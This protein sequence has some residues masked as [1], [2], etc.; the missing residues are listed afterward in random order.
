MKTFQT[1]SVT[2]W[3]ALLVVT[4]SSARLY[5][6]TPVETVSDEVLIRGF[7]QYLPELISQQ[8]HEPLLATLFSINRTPPDVQR[9]ILE[10]IYNSVIST[11]P[12]KDRIATVR[13]FDRFTLCQ[14]ENSTISKRATF[15]KNAV[16]KLLNRKIAENQLPRIGFCFSGGGIRAAVSADGF[17]KGLSKTGILDTGLYAAALS[18]STWLLA[19]WITSGKRY[20]DFAD[21]LLV[22]I[23]NGIIGKKL[24]EQIYDL[25]SFSSVIISTFLRRIA[26]EELPTVIDIYGLMLGLTLLGPNE[27]KQLLHLDLTSQAPHINQGQAPFP[28]YSAVYVKNGDNAPSYEW[29][30]FSPFEVTC[31][32]QNA[33]APAWAFGRKFEKGASKNAAP[34]LPL[35]Y[36]MGIWGS[37]ISISCGE[38]FGMI[39]NKLE[40][41]A[42]FDP[43]K[44]LLNATTVGDI[45]IFP[46]IVRNPTYHLEQSH[47]QLVKAHTIIDAGIPCNIPLPP[48]LHRNLDI[49][50]IGDFSSDLEDANELRRAEKYAR[51]HNLPFPKI[52]Y[53][54]ISTRTY[55]IFGNANG[56]APIVV[57]IPLVKNTRYLADFDPIKLMG[58]GHFMN[59]LNLNY[60]I[61]QAKTLAGLTEFTVTEM[62]QLLTKLIAHVV[63]KKTLSVPA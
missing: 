52:N 31:Y 47:D 15:C 5:A 30:E 61:D 38:L 14:D 19:P 44:Q 63:D 37:A 12:Y 7:E 11:N 27:K 1:R 53:E 41:Q 13:T 29:V 48:L 62:K 60:S 21:E 34:S 6:D 39:V 51:T 54:G 50:I 43:L 59:I 36:L 58:I 24:S 26:F 45:R 10:T 9:T 32:D 4:F 40:P 16:E 49:I 35:C 17:M 3:C 33:A 46:A 55:T 56:N 57:Y 2:L 25:T 8:D 42:L 22:R 18:G 20:E 28:L 23:S